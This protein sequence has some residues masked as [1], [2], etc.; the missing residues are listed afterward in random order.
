MQNDSENAMKF[1]NCFDQIAQVG[2]LFAWL[3]FY[4]PVNSYGHFETVSSH[5]HTFC[6]G[7]LDLAANQYFVH[8]LYFRL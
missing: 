7:K 6:L 3:R 8:I 5:N 1:S 2:E 4:I